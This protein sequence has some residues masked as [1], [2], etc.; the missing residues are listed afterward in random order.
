MECKQKPTIS[1]LNKVDKNH[2]FHNDAKIQ[3]LCGRSLTQ[4]CILKHLTFGDGVDSAEMAIIALAYDK[5]C[6]IA[7]EVLMIVKKIYNLNLQSFLLRFTGTPSE[8][9][10]VVLFLPP[11][12]NLLSNLLAPPDIVESIWDDLVLY[13]MDGLTTG[14]VALTI[15]LCWAAVLCKALVFVQSIWTAK[16]DSGWLEQR[17]GDE[18]SPFDGETSTKVYSTFDASP[19]I[20]EQQAAAAAPL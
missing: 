6:T 3:A 1:N 4:H 20:Y 17:P 16:G 10:F 15:C 5:E 7:L 13:F 14:D 19:L 9:L 8:Q 18:R 2:K 12:E 11:F